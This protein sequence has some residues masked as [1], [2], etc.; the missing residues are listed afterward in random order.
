MR[1]FSLA[2]MIDIMRDCAGEDESVHLDGD[3]SDTPFRDIG[4]DSLAL[5][6]TVARIE[7]D[8]GVTLDDEDVHHAETPRMLLSLVN[9]RLTAPTA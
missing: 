2:E 3:I 1:E 6:E 7:R 9:S 8:Y 4:Y 5:L